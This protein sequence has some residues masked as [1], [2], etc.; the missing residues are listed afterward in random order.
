MD[1]VAYSNV[2]I[3]G[4]DQSGHVRRDGDKHCQGCSPVL[5]DTSDETQQMQGVIL[6]L[7]N[8]NDNVHKEN[9]LPERPASLDGQTNTKEEL[10]CRR[11]QLKTERPTSV[12]IMPAIGPRKT[13]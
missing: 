7:R 13:E 3:Y 1:D 10:A 4:V 2:R 5:Y 9:T 6:P 8:R 11:W 12:T